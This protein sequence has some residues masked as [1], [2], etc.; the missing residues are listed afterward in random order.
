MFDG[1]CY[2]VVF[3]VVLRCGRLMCV[4]VGVL[5]GDGCGVLLCWGYG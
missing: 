5:V 3:G 2:C 1:L 4:V